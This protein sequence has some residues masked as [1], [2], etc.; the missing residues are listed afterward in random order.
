MKKIVTLIALVSSTLLFAQKTN[1]TNAAM[2][3]KAYE[4]AKFGGDFEQ[5]AK[6][7]LEAKSYID[8]S[9]EHVDTKSDPK[10]L[11]YLGFIYIE[12]PICAQMSG[13]A[14]LKAV[15]PEMAVEKGFKA[16][17]DSRKND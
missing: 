1:T 9:S 10:T 5:A 15:D 11:M 8:L 2:A 17:E 3:Y 16:L 12:I 6:D 14:T 7:L 4:S 13:D